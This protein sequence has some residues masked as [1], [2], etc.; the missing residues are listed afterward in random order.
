[1]LTLYSLRL[2]LSRSVGAFSLCVFVL[3]FPCQCQ[4][5]QFHYSPLDLCNM[6]RSVNKY[7]KNSNTWRKTSS[8]LKA[9]KPGFIS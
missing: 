5:L 4:K 1:M 8:R 2:Q 9:S 3:I 6:D 7:D